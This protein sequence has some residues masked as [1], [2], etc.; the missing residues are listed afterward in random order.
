MC[1]QIE[2]LRKSRRF[3]IWF[4][5]S[6][7]QTTWNPMSWRRTFCFRGEEI[8]L[9]SACCFSWG[10]WLTHM[11]EGGFSSLFT[12]LNGSS[13]IGWDL[14]TKWKLRRHVQGQSSENQ[15]CLKLCHG[16]GHIHRY[17]AVTQEPGLGPVSCGLSERTV[18]AHAIQSWRH[19]ILK[20]NGKST[21]VPCRI[22]KFGKWTSWAMFSILEI[23]MWQEEISRNKSKSKQWAWISENMF[24][25]TGHSSSQYFVGTVSRAYFGIYRGTSLICKMTQYL[26][27][28]YTILPQSLNH[29]ALLTTHNTVKVLWSHIV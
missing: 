28:A 26:Y 29:H 19:V 6:K 4:L 9:A 24:S 13:V 14:E 8:H 16:R 2:S 21:L 25:F 17:V 7:V 23:R 18:A 5:E 11:D 20:F 10:P 15:G 3:V 1:S 22:P 12:D 27:R